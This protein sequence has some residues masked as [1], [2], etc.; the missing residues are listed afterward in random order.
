MEKQIKDITSSI[1]ELIEQY[2]N[3]KSILG[4][5]NAEL[6][7]QS[8]LTSEIIVTLDKIQF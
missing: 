6:D 5:I 1:D 3:I 4:D 8:D 2:D 7:K